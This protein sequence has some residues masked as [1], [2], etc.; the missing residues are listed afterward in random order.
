MFPRLCDYQDTLIRS[1]WSVNWGQS[2]PPIHCGTWSLWPH[3]HFPHF[4]EA[5]ILFQVYSWGKEEKKE[6]KEKL[7]IAIVRILFHLPWASFSKFGGVVDTSL[8]IFSGYN[9]SYHYTYYFQ[10]RHHIGQRMEGRG[11]PRFEG[12]QSHPLALRPWENY[13][14]CVSM[15]LSQKGCIYPHWIVVRLR[16]IVLCETLSTVSGTS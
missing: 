1:S 7:N 6:G 12:Q 2:W 16:S 11:G 13:F 15:A 8:D 3:F 9:S 14:F 10:G 5:T 4:Q